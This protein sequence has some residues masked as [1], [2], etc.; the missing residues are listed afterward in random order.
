MIAVYHTN[1]NELTNEFL[2]NLKIQFKNAKVDIVI[3]DVSET[4][5]L[6]SSPK[7]REL[8][9]KAIKEVN[10]MKLINKSIEDLNL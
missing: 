10:D 5:Y 8:L 2:E 7:N 6:N 9:E 4:D 3:S 1:I